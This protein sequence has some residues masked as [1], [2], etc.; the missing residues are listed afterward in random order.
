M[1]IAAM[2][3]ALLL[4]FLA[5]VYRIGFEAQ[6]RAVDQVVPDDYSARVLGFFDRWLGFDNSSP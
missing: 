1:W 6:H 2:I 4:A 3:V 5:A